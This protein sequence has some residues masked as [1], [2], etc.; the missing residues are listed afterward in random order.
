MSDTKYVRYEE[1][2]PEMIA[3][4]TDIEMNKDDIKSMPE[5]FRCSQLHLNAQHVNASGASSVSCT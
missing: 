5:K 1:V 3:R 4:E 2:D